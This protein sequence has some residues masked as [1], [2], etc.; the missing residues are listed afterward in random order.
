MADRGKW[1]G[2][3]RR[4]PA[5]AA[6]IAGMLLSLAA[7]YV[8]PAPLLCLPPLLVFGVLAWFRLESAICL[9][10]L[11]FPLWYVPK[12]VTGQVVFPLS[13]IV[14]A[15]CATVALAQGARH[16]PALRHRLPRLARLARLARAALGRSGPRLA[17][18]ALLL[19]L[20]T[21]IGIVIAPRP[22]EALRAWR[23]EVAEPL[24]YFALVVLVVRRPWR[25][26]HLLVWVMLG[27]AAMV[28]GLATIQ[29]FWLHVTFAPLAQ[30]NKLMP[31]ATA[32]GAVPRAT[33]IIYGS[34]N[35]LGAWLARAIPLAL[36]LAFTLVRGQKRPGDMYGMAGGAE[37]WLAGICALL[38]LPALMWSASRGAWVACAAGCAIVAG[39]WLWSA[40]ST[41]ATRL[42]DAWR[43]RDR[44]WWRWGWVV[45]ALG[46]LAVALLVVW[47]PVVTLAGLLLAG[48]GG[49]GEVRLLLWRSALAMLRDHLLFGVG[50]DQFLS[51][52]SPNFSAHP[53]WIPVLNGHPTLAAREPDLSHPHNL[54]LEVWLNGGLLAVVGFVLLVVEALRRAARLHCGAAGWQS[55]AALGLLGAVVAMLV[56]GLVDSAYFAPDL[57]LWFW[58]ALALVV[59]LERTIPRRA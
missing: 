27:S 17:L 3:G 9:L 40:F 31:F 46:V 43:R 33:A 59:T 15:I 44:G 19:A 52:Y 26:A 41:R 25:A 11:T 13:E 54:L 24:L 42:R 51:Y 30:G 23:W 6:V 37:R 50:P 55:A 35:S 8:M 47:Q 16:L 28:A 22:H 10:P 18:G 58:W 2:A 5:E 4:A 29:V 21:A 36:A 45:A 12:P 34:G 48:H 38:C 1:T 49:S 53:Y 56:H 32:A 39:G 57:A 14:L 7:Y 20:G